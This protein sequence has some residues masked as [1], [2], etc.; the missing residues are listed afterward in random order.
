MDTRK[1]F[2]QRIEQL[3]AD[4]EYRTER[5]ILELNEEICRL[6]E[7]QKINRAELARRLGVQRQF[8]TKLLY[9]MPNLTLS[10][11]VKIA[12]ALGMHVDL[13]LAKQKQVAPAEAVTYMP[14]KPALVSWP[15]LAEGWT[16][17]IPQNILMTQEN[18]RALSNAA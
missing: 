2:K 13:K 14:C 17:D 7:E 6:M 9:G 5:L 4:P 8:I 10:T 15:L 3:E 18:T 12:T 11:L 16:A 1:W